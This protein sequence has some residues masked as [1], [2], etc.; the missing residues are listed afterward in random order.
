MSFVTNIC[1]GARDQDVLCASK[2]WQAGP[3][4]LD[5][6][7]QSF[8][9]AD[10]NVKLW[11]ACIYIPHC[12]YCIHINLK[13]SAKIVHFRQSNRIEGKKNIRIWFRTDYPFALNVPRVNRTL[14]NMHTFSE[15]EI[16]LL[17]LKDV[18]LQVNWSNFVVLFFHLITNVT[19]CTVVNTSWILSL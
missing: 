19:T 2:F 9:I 6:C 14:I 10:K 17:Y 18:T 5:A 8:S 15:R 4:M 7:P 3:F 11:T 13:F 1:L 16:F 12:E